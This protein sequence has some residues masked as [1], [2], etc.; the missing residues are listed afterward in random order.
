MS[1]DPSEGC[2]VKMFRRLRCSRI[3]LEFQSG[4]PQVTRKT[5]GSSP[6]SKVESR[7]SGEKSEGRAK[8]HK[9]NLHGE[10][11][12]QFDLERYDQR[13]PSGP[14]HI[15]FPPT[16]GAPSARTQLRSRDKAHLRL[17]RALSAAKRAATTFRL[18]E[19]SSE[20]TSPINPVAI[21]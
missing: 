21:R 14:G 5:P 6:S 13:G 20:R 2:A 8:F 17:I 3:K 12:W 16:L 1:R 15:R 18:I 4:T 19:N 9:G 11:V 7:H 10:T